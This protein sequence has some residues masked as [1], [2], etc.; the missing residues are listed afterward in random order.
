MLGRWWHS[1][2]TC[3]PPS[4]GSRPR[5]DA[6]VNSLVARG[7]RECYI[8]VLRLVKKCSEGREG[9]TGKE[10][11]VGACWC[12]AGGSVTAA[13]R[14]KL[15]TSHNQEHSNIWFCKGTYISDTKSQDLH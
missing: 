13:A 12:R 15:N 9:G 3:T 5:G 7:G 10:V 6:Q 11:A 8:V 1:G 2:L 4:Q 14:F